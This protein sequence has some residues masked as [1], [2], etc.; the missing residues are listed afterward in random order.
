MPAVPKAFQRRVRRHNLAVLWAAGLS[1][2][3]AVALWGLGAV[4][5]YWALLVWL[6]VSVSPTAP[7]PPGYQERCLLILAMVFPALWLV[8]RAASH[9]FAE[10][11]HKH[12]LLLG[13]LEIAAL[14]MRVTFGTLTNLGAWVAL[15]HRDK[16]TAVA[17]LRAIDEN[18]RLEMRRVELEIPR[19]A[20]REKILNALAFMELTQLMRY[21][22]RTV[23]TL[24][25][26][27]E[28][29]RLIY[30]RVQFQKAHGPRRKTPR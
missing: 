21:D 25:N 10:F 5:V 14:P 1:L 15:N 29:G 24:S 19:R 28:V 4:A 12:P 11:F 22:G 2:L 8:E 17:L 3:A 26:P 9:L 13:F 27:V 23:I 16:K 18:K 6:A 7:A 30:P 20:Q